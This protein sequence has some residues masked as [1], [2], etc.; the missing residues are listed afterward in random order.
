VGL[1]LSPITYKCLLMVLYPVRRPITTL[2]CV[3]LNN[4]NQVLCS[5]VSARNQFSSLSL[6]TTK[7]TPQYQ[8]LVFHPA[9]YVSSYILRRDPKKGSVPTNRW[10]E[11]SL[12]SLSAI[13]F[14]RT[15]ACAG[16]QYTLTACRVEISFSAFWHCRAKGDVGLATWSAFRATS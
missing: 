14:P 7:T 11:P 5:L 12:A 10:T 16:T 13:S 15:S 1:L 3:L 8:R 6:C 9:F 2:N 4:N